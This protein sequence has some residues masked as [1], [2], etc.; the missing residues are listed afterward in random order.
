MASDV[1]QKPSKAVLLTCFAVFYTCCFFR[2]DASKSSSYVENGTGNFT[3][4]GFGQKLWKAINSLFVL[5]SLRYPV[6][7]QL[8]GFLMWNLLFFR[9]GSGP[10]SGKAETDTACLGNACAMSQVSEGKSSNFSSLLFFC[11]QQ[12]A[13][14]TDVSGLG[15]G[16]VAGKFE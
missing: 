16:Y 13:L 12:F 9:Y 4:F 5:L 3:F 10:V 15:V 1:F 2:F 6:A 7:F 11:L 14:I 8:F